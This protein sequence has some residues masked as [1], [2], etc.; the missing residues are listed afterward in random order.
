MPSNFNNLTSCRSCRV[1]SGQ[2]VII[3]TCGV[4]SMPIVKT[5]VIPSIKHLL[6]CDESCLSF[7]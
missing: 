1:D 2:I 4:L 6:S 3:P 7:E 5:T